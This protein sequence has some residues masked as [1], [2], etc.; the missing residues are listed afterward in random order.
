MHPAGGFLAVYAYYSN[1]DRYDDS[2]NVQDGH[3][4]SPA[5]GHFYPLLPSPVASDIT[6]QP[7]HSKAHGK[8]LVPG[9][10]FALVVFVH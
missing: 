9:S 4:S 5:P 1:P 3:D 7:P 8:P 6:G 2:R 10:S